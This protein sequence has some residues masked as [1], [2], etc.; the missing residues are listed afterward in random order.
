MRNRDKNIKAKKKYKKIPR[1]KSQ[2]LSISR[3]KSTRYHAGNVLRCLQ[4]RWE[5]RGDIND[6]GNRLP[7]GIGRLAAAGSL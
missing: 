3:K 7:F 6:Q 1:N 2:V 5:L 4:R